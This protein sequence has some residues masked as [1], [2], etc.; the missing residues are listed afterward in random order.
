[1]AGLCLAGAGAHSHRHG[2]ES[3]WQYT[4]GR[5][6]P[7]VP[8]E[9]LLKTLGCHLGEISTS[10]RR[11]APVK[12]LLSDTHSADNYQ[13]VCAA[14]V[15]YRISSTASHQTV[16]TSSPSPPPLTRP[17]RCAGCHR[18]AMPLV[19]VAPASF[20]C[21]SPHRERSDTIPALANSPLWAH[22]T[23]DPVCAAA[24]SRVL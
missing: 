18:L 22:L 10:D 23:R 20:S 12:K 11:A 7:C 13:Y 3:G 5:S 19:I 8:L 6:C 14:A 1:M 4:C 17:Q 2:Q 15:P 16:Q 24:A 21:D 9:G